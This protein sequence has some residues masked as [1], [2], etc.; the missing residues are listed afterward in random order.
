MGERSS[1][2]LLHIAEQDIDDVNRL[3]IVTLASTLVKQ[4]TANNI[5]PSRFPTLHKIASLLPQPPRD[6]LHLAMHK[7]SIAGRIERCDANSSGASRLKKRF[8]PRCKGLAALRTLHHDDTRL[9][10]D[11]RTHALRFMKW[12]H[13]CGALVLRDNDEMFECCG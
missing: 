5:E 4:R 1:V 6:H 11:L 2:A 12:R 7:I 10:R 13:R 9:R 3:Q 8:T